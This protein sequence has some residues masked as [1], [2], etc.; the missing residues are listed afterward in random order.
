MKHLTLKNATG[1]SRGGHSKTYPAGTICIVYSAIDHNQHLDLKWLGDELKKARKLNEGKSGPPAY[2][3]VIVEGEFITVLPREQMAIA[4]CDQP[5]P[6]IHLAGFRSA[7]I[8]LQ[9]SEVLPA[10]APDPVKPPK[11]APQRSLFE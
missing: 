11:K 3:V 2:L 10:A 4:E 5:E 6:A 7:P 9:Q 8:T 1:F